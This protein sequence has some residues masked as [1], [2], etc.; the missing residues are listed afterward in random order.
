MCETECMC[1]CMCVHVCLSMSVSVC[2]CA[3]M[4]VYMHLCVCVGGGGYVCVSACLSSSMCF[5]QSVNACMSHPKH[6]YLPL[7][8]TVEDTISFYTYFLYSLKCLLVIFS[9]PGSSD[10]ANAI[11]PHHA[12]H[13]NKQA[14]T[15]CDLSLLPPPPKK[16]HTHNNTQLIPHRACL[17]KSRHMDIYIA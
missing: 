13:I 3:C 10:P 8:N 6:G 17:G 15:F 1:A 12:V 4:H 2:L 16:K 11:I 9:H 7:S 14:N 5:C